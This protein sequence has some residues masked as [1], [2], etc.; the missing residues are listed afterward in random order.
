MILNQ[1]AF[2]KGSKKVRLKNKHL[3]EAFDRMKKVKTKVAGFRQRDED[4]YGQNW[5]KE[6]D[7]C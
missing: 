6:K 5:W 2:V 3:D 1:K 4:W 7:G